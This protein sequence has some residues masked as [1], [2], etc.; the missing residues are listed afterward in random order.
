M[1]VPLF[2][3]PLEAVLNCRDVLCGKSITDNSDYFP[4]STFEDY[5]QRDPFLSLTQ[6]DHVGNLEDRQSDLMGELWKLILVLLSCRSGRAW[7]WSR[8]CAQ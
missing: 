3:G 4:K 1:A 6:V 5:L 7:M 8:Q 2:R